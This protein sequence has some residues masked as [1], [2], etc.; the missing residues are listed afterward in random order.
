MESDESSTTEVTVE[1]QKMLICINNVALKIRR[2]LSIIN[3]LVK[4][5]GQLF[6]A[7]EGANQSLS[8]VATGMGINLS[9]LTESEKG[10]QLNLPEPLTSMSVTEQ[11]LSCIDE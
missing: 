2:E 1:L 3:E 8:T 9:T 5:N 11:I 6:M 7:V 4:E 10:L